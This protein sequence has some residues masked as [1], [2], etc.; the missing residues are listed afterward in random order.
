M[1]GQGLRHGFSNDDWGAAKEE[2]R[3]AMIAKA[4]LRGMIT[5]S[6]LVKSIRRIK[7]DPHDIRLSHMLGEISSE[8]DRSGRGMLTVVVVH[9]VGDMEPGPGF[10]ELAKTLGRDTSN[11]LRC[12]VNELHAVHGFWSKR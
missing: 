2:A 7:L 6:D 11:L 12:W 5:Y 9:K 8:E 3:D 1:L 10:Y 4:K